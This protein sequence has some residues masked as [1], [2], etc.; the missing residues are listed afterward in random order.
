MPELKREL[1]LWTAIA[2]VIGTTIGSAI[3]IVPKTMILDLGSPGLVFSAWIV[4]GVLSLFGALTYA[5]L[6]SMYPEAGAEYTY[7]REAYGRF[8][9]FSYGWSQ[10]WVGRSG[11]MATLA[12][13]MFLYLAH[14][15]PVLETI[16]FTIP[17]PV[18]PN[19]GPL[20]IRYGQ[21]LGILVIIALGWV[22]TLGIRVG[23][24]VHLLLTIVKL[25]LLSLIIGAG[26]FAAHGSF[27]HFTEHTAVTAS[28]GLTER[29]FGAL[30]AALWAY[31]GW[32]TIAQVGSEVRDPQRNLPRALI[33]GM[34]GIIF[35]Y[36]LANVAYFYVLTPGE[37][38]KG[39]RVAAEMMRHVWGPGGASAVS[40]AAVL[41]IL[42][43]L[44]GTLIG[45]S[46]IPFAMAR[47]GLFTRAAAQI[48]PTHHTP[49]FSIWTITACS[50]LILL[51]GRYEEL[52]TCVIFSSWILYAMAAFSVIVLRRKF[53]DLPRPYR[54]PG[55][56]WLPIVFTATAGVLLV[57]TLRRSPRESLIGIGILLLGIPFYSTWSKRA[58]ER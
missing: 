12:T 21:V 6:A 29:F 30:I 26:L 55:Y 19:F 54:V 43:A 51:S 1:G 17:L 39:D 25:G 28:G 10:T 58:T 40:I 53:P 16:A 44:N 22:N 38:G 4:G 56:P 31:E 23:G 18:G 57:S 3:F 52:Y 13:G 7:L 50:A 37:V 24:R 11:S 45:G 48:N 9:G 34:A 2:I 42:A 20:D 8:W 14:F 15:F 49:V 35:V 36:L 32:S 41:S 46:R 47:D 27:G 33:G 5:E